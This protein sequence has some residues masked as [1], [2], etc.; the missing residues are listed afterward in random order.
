MGRV[1][2]RKE[3]SFEQEMHIAFSFLILLLPMT[4][5]VPSREN[6]YGQYFIFLFKNR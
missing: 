2:R 3:Y 4:K 1:Q 5:F 6:N